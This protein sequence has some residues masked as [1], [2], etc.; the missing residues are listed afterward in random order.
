MKWK[1]PDKG[2]NP[3]LMVT[4][5]REIFKSNV[6][7]KTTARTLL[8]ILMAVAVAR[9]FRINEIARRLA[10]DVKTERA[11][12]KR[13]LRFLDTPFPLLAA[14][15][16]WATFVLKR[17]WTSNT[18][19]HRL[20][21]I[22]ETK[23]FGDWKAIVAAVPFRNRAIPVFW[24]VYRDQD[25]D[26]RYKSHNKLVQDFCQ[27]AYN[28]ALAVSAKKPMLIFDRGFARAKYII[29]FLMEKEIP[30]VMRV[31]RH[32][33]IT[34]N[35]THKKLHDLPQGSY[36]SI[37]YHS[38]YQIP[39][40][41]YVL[42]NAETY[43]EP[44][45]LISNVLTGPQIYNLYKRRMQIEHAFRDIKSTFG[46]AKL[47]LKKDQRARIALLWFIAVLTYGLLFLAY[48]RPSPLGKNT[49]TNRERFMRLLRLSN[50]SLVS[51]GT[52]T[53]CFHF[54]EVR[55]AEADPQPPETLTFLTTN[56]CRLH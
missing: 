3:K 37:G 20:L 12:Q 41:L 15:Q 13:V 25:I 8:L 24:H 55:G 44:M 9:T 30:F 40:A 1:S 7:K 46:F 54:S 51:F 32:V 22:D 10:I 53:S 29:K 2:V 50:A 4:H 52:K 16:A 33:G 43:K 42:R 23:L 28:R 47:V 5:F 36:P 11:K 26:L 31:C 49:P 14:K 19:G 56:P 45:Y 21:L 6:L 48:E 38:T 27:G 35:Q 18:A 34:H 39:L 17:L